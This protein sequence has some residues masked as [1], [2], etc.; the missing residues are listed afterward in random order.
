VERAKELVTSFGK[1]PV[2]VSKYIPGFVANRFLIPMLIQAARLQEEGVA[3]K[4]EIGLLVKK[5][6]GFQS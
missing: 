5:G 6:I 4:E 1:L 3:S 2:V